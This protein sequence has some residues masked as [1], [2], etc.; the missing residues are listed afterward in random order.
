MEKFCNKLS[1]LLAD[2]LTAII[3]L[4]SSAYRFFNKKAIQ[5]SFDTAKQKAIELSGF[6]TFE[7]SMIFHNNNM[8][9]RFRLEDIPSSFVVTDFYL[10]DPHT[11]IYRISAPLASP[12]KM[13]GNDLRTYLPREI[14]TRIEAVFQDP[15]IPTIYTTRLYFVKVAQSHQSYIDIFIKVNLL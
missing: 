13:D 7:L 10:P 14:E 1:D 2:L 15:F 11:V 12:A 5:V 8:P 9:H 4:L 6:V 3:A